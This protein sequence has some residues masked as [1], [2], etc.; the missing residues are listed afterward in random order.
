MK[1]CLTWV[2]RVDI[3][4][5]KLAHA[6]VHLLLEI[7]GD[8]MSLCPF[9]L[10]SSCLDTIRIVWLIHCALLY[11]ELYC[12]WNNYCQ[13]NFHRLTVIALLK[14]ES[15]A[16]LNS[17]FIICTWDAFQ[18]SPPVNYS[19][20]LS[21]LTKT[22]STHRHTLAMETIFIMSLCTFILPAHFTLSS[23]SS[24]VLVMSVMS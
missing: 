21:V 23:L 20:V 18:F 4:W 24:F 1:T 19:F 8:E 7:T 22:K 11:T 3:E 15:N 5:S 12:H 16:Q 10:L 9:S 14:D 17:W 13:G 6:M 2:A